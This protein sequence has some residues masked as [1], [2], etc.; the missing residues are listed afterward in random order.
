MEAKEENIVVIDEVTFC[1]DMRCCVRENCYPEHHI[2]RGTNMCKYGQSHPDV[3]CNKGHFVGEA[4]YEIHRN[5]SELPDFKKC[6][7]MF[8][9]GIVRDELGILYSQSTIK[10]NYANRKALCEIMKRVPWEIPKRAPFSLVPYR[11]GTSRSASSVLYCEYM[12]FC[13]IGE[14]CAKQHI[15]LAKSNICPS[16]IKCYE[17]KCGKHHFARWD[18]RRN[19][20]YFN[21]KE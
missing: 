16:G 18:Y 1:T 11:R 19:R 10:H 5:P 3:F 17:K 8:C 6:K 14:M 20:D 4:S 15:P 2:P 21:K 7:H 13:E 9:V 12:S